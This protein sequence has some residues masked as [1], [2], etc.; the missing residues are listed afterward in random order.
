MAGEEIAGPKL[1]GKAG[2]AVAGTRL[3]RKP[4]P[5]DLIV[6][7]PPSR[8]GRRLQ[9]VPLLAD[10]LGKALGVEVCNTIWTRRGTNVL[11]GRQGRQG[12][13]LS[14]APC[15]LDPN[16]CVARFGSQPMRR[17][18]GRVCR[19]DERASLST[20]RGKITRQTLALLTLAG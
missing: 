8:P 19:V 12:G 7:V 18:T 5:V 11:L 20:Y 17:R 13:L 9:P 4:R 14:S 1:V 6:A 15:L 16:G 3:T 10:A 2:F